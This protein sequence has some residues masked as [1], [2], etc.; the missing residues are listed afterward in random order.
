[1]KFYSK[2]FTKEQKINLEWFRLYH[3]AQEFFPFLVKIDKIDF[4]RSRINMQ[5]I[6][7]TTF[8]DKLEYID[9]EEINDII[10]SLIDIII[11]F[12]N[13][14][15]ENLYV[16][17]TDLSLDNIMVKDG[18]TAIDPT[19]VVFKQHFDYVNFFASL[20]FL[21]TAYLE[22]NKKNKIE[23]L[24]KYHK[25]IDTFTII[26]SEN[27]NKFYKEKFEQEINQWG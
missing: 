15:I 2:T 9:Y 18:I 14:P 1:M 22:K 23:I 26:R 13:N 8:Q 4:M 11:Y 17:H 12:Y 3:K 21:K 5:Y 7:G 27:F 10:L 19:S 25:H 20:Q 6:E 16:M 24:R